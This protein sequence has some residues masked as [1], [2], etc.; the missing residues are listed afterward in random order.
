MPTACSLFFGAVHWYF[1]GFGPATIEWEH[2]EIE[3]R[4]FP[5]FDI[6]RQVQRETIAIRSDG[7]R[8]IHTRFTTY[9]HYFFE[10]ETHW[11]ILLLDAP[12]QRYTVLY[13][14]QREA[15]W[16]PL[17]CGSPPVRVRGCEPRPPELPRLGCGGVPVGAGWAPSPILEG[18]WRRAITSIR[19]GEPDPQ[20]FP[21]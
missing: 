12:R 18:Y 15:K 9:H 6:H 19:Y 2:A 10:I 1:A 17:P 16:R 4:L 5:H 11:S 14:G 21:F 13:D 8:A 20:L 7:S 3:S